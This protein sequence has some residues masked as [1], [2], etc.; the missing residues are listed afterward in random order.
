MIPIN[1]FQKTFLLEKYFQNRHARECFKEC[2]E[3]SSVQNFN[4][5]YL[6]K[7]TSQHSYC[8]E[9][10][11]TCISFDTFE[12]QFGIQHSSTQCLDERYAMVHYPH[13]NRHILNLRRSGCLT[14]RSNAVVFQCRG[15]SKE[16]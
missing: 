9:I 10:F 7:C 3:S 15:Y 11:K 14:S 8:L 4:I 13:K 16:Q 6:K 1:I 2:F 12:N 5:L